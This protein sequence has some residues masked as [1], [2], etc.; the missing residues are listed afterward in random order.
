ME[1]ILS[2]KNLSVQF[3][4]Y[5][6]LKNINFDV[7]EGD[8]ISIVGPNGAGKSTLVKAILGLVDISSGER[9]F[10]NKNIGY[11]PQRAF[12]KDSL[13]PATVKEVVSHGLL[14]S[15]KHPKMI[16]SQDKKNIDE[17]LTKLQIIDLK[18]RKIGTLSGGQQQ[19]VFLARA[20]ISNPKMLILD[21]PASALDP[22]FRKDFYELLK[23][24][25]QE[26][27]V[28]I[29]HVTH[30]I[31]SI[32]SCQDKILFIDREVI[33]FGKYHDYLNSSHYVLHKH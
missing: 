20:L 15:K 17:I 10:E 2:V 6:A 30:D 9:Y 22:N 7:N 33:F 29:L 4:K 25:N 24:L 8:Y 12:T 3:G 5:Q 16:N 26:E 13:F 18:D 32:E 21:E 31:N 14:A 23:K 28:T 19:R 27:H 11:L 1:N